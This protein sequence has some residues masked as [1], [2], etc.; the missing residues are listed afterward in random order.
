LIS[1]AI[2]YRSPERKLEITI[3]IKDLED[4]ISLSVADNGIG[5][6]IEKINDVFSKFKR[7]HGTLENRIE[8]TGIGL[9]LVRKIVENV[10][11]RIDVSSTVGSGSIFTVWF[12]KI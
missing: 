11:G 3:H 12:P 1:N 7:V 9:Y 6:S 2:K 8:G 4:Y 10:N 5:I